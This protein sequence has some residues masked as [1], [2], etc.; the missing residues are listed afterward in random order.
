M[1]KKIHVLKL[2][3]YTNI[4]IQLISNFTDFSLNEIYPS[5]KRWVKS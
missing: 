4:I 5:L 1:S 3:V 2:L